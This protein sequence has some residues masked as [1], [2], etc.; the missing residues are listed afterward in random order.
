M[1]GSDLRGNVGVVT[2]DRH[3]RR[4]ALDVEHCRA[5]RTTVIALLAQGV[6][7]LVVT[8][9]GTTFCAGADLDGVHGEEF[10]EALYGALHALTTA[11]VPVLAAVNGP[12]VG[13]G[14]QLALACDLR[15]VA[16]DAFF[17]VPTATNGLAVDPWTVRRLA[18]L[19]GGGA[20][21]AMLLGCDRID[22]SLALQR[23]LADR[24]GDTAAALAWADE[25]THLAPLSLRYSKLALDTLFEP[26]EWEP[27]L[28][29]RFELVWASEDA[30][31]GRQARVE[32]RQPRFHGR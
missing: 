10:R 8:G 18:L 12:A 20:A 14:T 32:R 25:I 2:V 24:I 6:R 9:S 15:V 26:P 5:L 4:N 31:E 16:P 23:G 19:A 13:A 21:R 29:K 7:A 28:D 3:E 17:S 1:I 22:A 27:E 11:Q 30:A